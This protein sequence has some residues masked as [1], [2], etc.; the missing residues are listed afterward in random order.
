MIFLLTYRVCIHLYGIFQG[1]NSIQIIYK[2]YFTNLFNLM[3]CDKQTIAGNSVIRS[4][5]G[6]PRTTV[7]ISVG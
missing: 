3:H 1:Q 2:K 5:Y 4:Q 6:Q 7:I